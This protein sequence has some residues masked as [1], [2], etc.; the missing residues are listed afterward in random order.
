MKPMNTAHNCSCSSCNANL[1]TLK[2]ENDKR[3]SNY[4]YEHH[5][6]D[7][8]H[9]ISLKEER[10]LSSVIPIKKVVELVIAFT[11]LLLGALLPIT[12]VLKVTLF[13]ISYVSAGRKVVLKAFKGI[14][15]GEL[16]DENF[17]MTIASIAA[18]FTGDYPEGVAVIIFY[19]AGQ[20]LEDMAINRSRRSIQSL[21]DIKPE[22]ARIKTDAGFQVVSPE[23]V[24]IDSII[25]V[26]AGEKIP[27]DGI[28]ID[29]Q[30]S[31]D[32]SIITG[33]SML[34]QV[35][36]DTEVY[37]GSINIDG[38]LQI[39][40]TKAFTDSTVN[41]ILEL[42]ESANKQK[43]NTEKFITK[44]AKYYTPAV[45]GAA[46]VL[47]IIPPIIFGDSFFDWFYKAAIFLV[48]SC[49]CGLVISVPLGYFGGI[50]GASKSGILVKGGNYLE[51]LKKASIVV[52][53]KTGTIT[54]GKFEVTDII[55]NNTENDRDTL[56]E[57]AA[58]IEHYSH[59][60]IAN[61]IVKAYKGDL[62]ESRVKDVKE[63]QGK[64][65]KA[66]YD[67][68]QILI[69]N[70]KL[71]E[72]NNISID[73]KKVLGTKVYIANENTFLGTILIADS[74]KP[75][76]KESINE[77]KTY[78]VKEV[79][80]LT[81]DYEEVASEV[82]NEVGITKYFSE[83]LPHHKVEKLEEIINGTN[84]KEKVL[85]VGDGINDAPVIARADAGIAM[86]SVGSDATIEAA[87]VVIMTDQLSSLPKSIKIAR[88]TNRIVWQN[89]IFSF[90]VK[91]LILILAIVGFGNMW[92][93]VF[94]DVGVAAIAILNAVR[95]LNVK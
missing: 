20:I 83:L 36:K 28:V 62:D 16:L 45:V 4:D 7:H 44:F 5:G 47:A 79:I 60:P 53:D 40:V 39:R 59:H 86:G 2:V 32:T 57:M 84:D 81:G 31:I 51:I 90:G 77:L 19:G 69:G 58:N 55:P 12:E 89:I 78:G 3:Q 37:S 26:K 30:S 8:S 61:S 80:M 67:N 49:P 54:K 41:R 25:M 23:K 10:P 24:L 88:F 13:V 66:L 75:D 72:D 50:G 65:L 46:G 52:M 76:A 48:V 33:E 71:M 85:F 82:A 56:L 93:A 21:L 9:E 92:L 38:V 73:H 64:G 94:A 15:H 43:A 17:L 91:A 68:E 63:I 22:M 95:A 74:I 18:F 6:H 11:L 29:G 27:L 70:M 14:I 42:V 87:D 1:I 35:S 34:R